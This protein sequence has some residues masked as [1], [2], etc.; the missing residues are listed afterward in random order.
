MRVRSINI[1]NNQSIDL[2]NFTVLVGPNNVGKSQT[3]R[4]IN[5]KVTEGVN[6][7]T[8]LVETINIE[9]PS[10]REQVL[11][12]LNVMDHPQQI[13]NKLVRGI[14]SD[15]RSGDEI[16]L[17]LES[18]LQQYDYAQDASFLL[19]ALGRFKV[20]FLDAY[21]RLS[22]ASAADAFNPHT[23]PPRNLLQD[24]FRAGAPKE[25]EL[26]DAFKRTFGMDIKLD[27]SGL[28]QLY[29]RVAKEFGDIPA[30]PR[31]AY[32][33]MSQYN[34]LDVQGD[35]F[36][37]FVGVVLSLLLSEGRI[38]L[39]DEPEAFLHPAQARRLGTWVADYAKKSTSQLVVATH[40]ANFLGGILAANTP[41][42]IFRL[43]RV[44]NETTYNKIPARAISQLTKSPLLSSQS[45]LDAVFQRGVVVCEADSD[46]TVYQTVAARQLGNQ[47]ALFIHAQSKQ[48]VKD[49]VALLRDATIPVCAVVDIDILNSQGDFRSLIEALSPEFDSLDTSE[50]CK[51][52]ALHVEGSSD[53]AV[54]EQLESDV[55]QLLD[56]MQRGE[57]SLAGARSALARIRDAASRWSLLKKEGIS[58]LPAEL[59]AD[60]DALLT[61]VKSIGLFIVPVGELEG[62]IDVGTRQKK[63]WI[64]L[65][66]EKLFRSECPEP[67]LAFVKEMLSFLGEDLTL[68]DYASRPMRRVAL[69]R[70]EQ[71]DADGTIN[72]RPTNTVMTEVQRTE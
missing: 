45:V 40:N 22:V 51:R 10:T 17:N 64:V 18:L 27:Y 48:T 33:I 28:T 66:L 50:A 4:D 70:P 29:L 23:S 71:T 68:A 53:E 36:R 38:V 8:T 49:V 62:W 69:E 67:L 30:D 26:R 13:G 42:D 59:L 25:S 43:N 65:A 39:L 47:E 19:P 9:K 63:R 52:I 55:Q 58:A 41:V 12:G 1:K 54:L 7:R 46:R 56:Q 3:L 34:Q 21:S 60:A 57:H 37:S 14:T 20:A 44:G 5:S 24:L 35:G 6:S 72:R 15:L 16:Q 32:P 2:G 31:D 61:Q 11:H